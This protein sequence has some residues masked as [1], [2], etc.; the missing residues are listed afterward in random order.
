MLA[1]EIVQGVSSIFES[2]SQE[3]VV[4]EQLQVSGNKDQPIVTNSCSKESSQEIKDKYRVIH[5]E[6]D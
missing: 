5:S 1:P 3:E 4:F 6:D 2:C